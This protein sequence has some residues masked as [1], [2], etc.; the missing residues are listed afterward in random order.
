[1]LQLLPDGD[2]ILV[3]AFVLVSILNLD[4]VLQLH[5]SLLGWQCG[6]MHLPCP[7]L[8]KSCELWIKC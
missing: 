4:K 8:Y 3:W 5:D 1:V 7:W 2:N 6:S